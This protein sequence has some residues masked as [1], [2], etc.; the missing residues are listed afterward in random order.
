MAG[1]LYG[2]QAPAQYTYGAQ[3]P[4]ASNTGFSWGDTIDSAASW[5]DK[6]FNQPTMVPEGYGSRPISNMKNT[7]GVLQ[8]STGNLIDPST[9][10]VLMPNQTDVTQANAVTQPNIFNAGTTTPATTPVQTPASITS[11]DPSS[12]FSPIG[13]LNDINSAGFDQAV[14]NNTGNA[15]TGDSFNFDWQNQG[16]GTGSNF[17]SNGWDAMGG[18]E[19]LSQGL[20]ALSGV[21]QTFLGFQQLGQ[22]KD[23]LNFTKN[24]WQ[25]DYDMRLADYNRSVAR[26]ESKD[27]A[28][29]K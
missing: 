5:W 22:A 21:G 17:L 6:T 13:S 26:Q 1:Y 25:A 2:A 11:A 10:Q 4:K 14:A 29:S 19:G 8:A 27:E 9:G 15:M 7:T 16:T 28:L 12:L 23:Q 24:A 3:V 18:M 20:S